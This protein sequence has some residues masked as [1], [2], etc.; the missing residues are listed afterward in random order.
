MKPTRFIW[1]RNRN[2]AGRGSDPMPQIIYDDVG[3]SHLEIVASHDI[4]DHDFI[5]YTH[6][7][8]LTINALASVHPAP[9]VEP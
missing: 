5:D 4:V 2:A 8:G 7:H 6:T 3:V 1:A 9:R